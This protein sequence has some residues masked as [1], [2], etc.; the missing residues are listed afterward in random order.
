MAEF[1]EF[2]DVPENTEPEFLDDVG[3]EDEIKVFEDE[4]KE[5]VAEKLKVSITK[6]GG[7][8]RPSKKQALIDSIIEFRPYVND[9]PTNNKLK[10]MKISALE[11]LLGRCLTQASGL[12]NKTAPPEGEPLIKNPSPPPTSGAEALFLANVGIASVLEQIT[13]Q[14]SEYTGVEIEGWSQDLK[15]DKE[16]LINILEGVYREHADVCQAYLSP[17]SIYALYMLSSGAGHLRAK[18]KDS[19]TA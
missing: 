6:D 3:E 12:P 11:V 4:L 1:D 13:K 2:A 9:I 5:I 18:K 16:N 19:I 10:K 8:A 14:T 7:G 15:N 17:T